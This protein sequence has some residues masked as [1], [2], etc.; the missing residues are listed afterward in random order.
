MECKEAGF[1]CGEIFE[2]TRK[3]IVDIITKT[4]TATVKH[5]KYKHDMKT[6]L[7]RSIDNRECNADTFLVEFNVYRFNFNAGLIV[8]SSGSSMIL[9]AK[10]SDSHNVLTNVVRPV[11]LLPVTMRVN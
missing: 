3:F 4:C 2:N 5:G 1:G 9:C 7:T 8:S 11:P 10:T 6:E